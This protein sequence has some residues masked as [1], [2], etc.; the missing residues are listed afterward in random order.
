MAARAYDAQMLNSPRI[1]VRVWND[2]Q[3]AADWLGVKADR[4]TL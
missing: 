2:R 1:E 4:L 3:A